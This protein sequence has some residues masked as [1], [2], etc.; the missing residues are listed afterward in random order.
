[1]DGVAVTFSVS[2]PAGFIYG[3][4]AVLKAKRRELRL[5]G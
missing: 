1:M 4:R 3:R 2:G 5:L